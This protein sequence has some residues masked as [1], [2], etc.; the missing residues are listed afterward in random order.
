MASTLRLPEDLD[1]RLADHCRAVGATKNRVCVIAL[2]HY[3]GD[4]PPPR[5]ALTSTEPAAAAEAT[6]LDRKRVTV[7]LADASSEQW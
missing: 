2:K 4:A 1:A 7:G 5:V 6:R 3:V